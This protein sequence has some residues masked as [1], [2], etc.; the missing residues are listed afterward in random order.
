M[1]YHLRPP[2]VSDLIIAKNK[3]LALYREIKFSVFHKL[4][5]YII[6]NICFSNIKAKSSSSTEDKDNTEETKT[7]SEKAE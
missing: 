2:I 5:I 3:V 7:V 1:I 6:I 4:Y